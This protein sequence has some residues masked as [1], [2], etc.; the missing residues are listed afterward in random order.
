MQD[1]RVKYRINESKCQSPA[2]AGL[3]CFKILLDFPAV[4]L[5][6]YNMALPVIKRYCMPHRSD[7]IGDYEVSQ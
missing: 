1:I 2:H 7:T 3:F 4:I 6:L 5:Y